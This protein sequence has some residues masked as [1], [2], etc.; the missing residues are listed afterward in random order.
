MENWGKVFNQT[1][2]WHKVCETIL[3]WYNPKGS[4]SVICV[5]VRGKWSELRD[6]AS[7]NFFWN[8]VDTNYREN[9][10]RC[11]FSVRAAHEATLSCPRIETPEKR[12]QEMMIMNDDEPFMYVNLIFLETQSKKRGS[13]RLWWWLS[14]KRRWWWRLWA[15]CVNLELWWRRKKGGSWRW[16]PTCTL[17]ALHCIARYCIVCHCIVRNCIA[18]HCI[19]TW[20]DSVQCTLYRWELI[21]LQSNALC[22]IELHCD[23]RPPCHC[24]LH[25]K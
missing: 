14:W 10:K 15:E 17:I 1:D 6:R 25:F 20:W 3:R 24:P 23:W 9:F 22:G 21:N 8:E 19:A 4:P 11:N 12:T 7:I 16:A 18:L 5:S 2:L 13:W